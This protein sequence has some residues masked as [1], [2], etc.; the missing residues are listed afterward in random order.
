MEMDCRLCGN[1]LN[2]IE[3]LQIPNFPSVV[4]YFPKTVADSL[5]L[6]AVLFV[7]RCKYCNLVQLMN[8]PVWYYK[9]VIRSNSVSEEM[10]S[11]RSKQ[12]RSF[13]AE[14]DLTNKSILEVGCGQGE[15]LEILAAIE[16][17]VHGIEY[18]QLAVETCISKGLSVQK[19][20]MDTS[21]R[22]D[23]APFDAFFS[24]NVLEHIPDP[25]KWLRAVHGSLN[26][27]AFG[28]I[29]VPNFTL[30]EDNNLITE[31]MGDHL[32]Y[33]TEET[34][35]H[36]LEV[37]GF[38]VIRIESY[39]S[40]YVLSATVTKSTSFSH[41]NYSQY[42]CHTQEILNEFK[43][44]FREGEIAIWGAGHQSLAYINLFGLESIAKYVIDSAPFKQESFVPG[45]SLP[46]VS[47]ET[48]FRDTYVKCILVIAAGYN[49]EIIE[50]LH[51][52]QFGNTGEI[53]SFNHGQLV[54]WP[55]L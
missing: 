54:N 32:T 36:I 28:L 7:N 24:F 16:P 44:R 50:R 23:H 48:F 34:F 42:L 37:S 25:R 26:E 18:A 14:F 53:Y 15:N 1:P 29:E 33:F 12:F 19:C 38:R 45:T 5:N 9:E 3:S 8:N 52:S 31:F 4:Q 2:S 22:I 39:F 41:E 20:F 10:R 27:N 47:P 51:N 49:S 13:L 21:S 35:R 43:S 11:F 40:Q 17:R 46:I 30:I 55:K 6:K